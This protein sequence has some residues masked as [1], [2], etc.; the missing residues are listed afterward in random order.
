MCASNEQCKNRQRQ[1]CCLQQGLAMAVFIGR[2]PVQLGKP[3]LSERHCTTSGGHTMNPTVLITGASSG[4]GKESAVLFAAKGFNTVINCKSNVSGLSELA[5]KLE[6][7]GA[8]VLPVVKD[9]SDPAQAGEMFEIM[10]ANDMVPDI[11]INNAG[12]SHI[13][14]LQDMSFEEWS[15]VIGTNLTSVFNVCKCAIPHMLCLG[16]GRIINI[17]SM[18]GN[19]GASCEVAYSASKGGVNAFTKALAK[20]LAPSRIQVNAVAFGAVDTRMNSFLSEDELDALIEEIPSGR[21][22]SAAEAASI[23]YRVASLSEYVTGQII[24]A[25]GGLT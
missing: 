18:W 14:L 10:S 13:G 25:D 21:L 23:I 20:E 4:I 7:G 19:T 3:Q 24:T 9:V 6:A 15:N 22:C 8:K 5:S 1:T 16:G 17:S 2:Q 12:I 11:V